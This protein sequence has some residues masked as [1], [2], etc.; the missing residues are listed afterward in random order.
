MRLLTRLALAGRRW[1]QWVPLV[2]S[3]KGY[4]RADFSSDL[5]AGVVVGMVTVPQAVAYAY[6]AG[7]PPQAG[8][9]ACLLPMVIYAC[10]GSSRHLVVGPVAVAALLVAAAIAQHA[11]DYGDAHLMISSVLCLQVGLILLA[12]NLFKMG[13]LVNLLSHPVITGWLNRFTKP[14]ILNR[15]RASKI[16]P[17]CRHSTLEI[18]RCASP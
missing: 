9:Y 17:T 1:Q 6:L 11:P 8:L 10:L 3:L 16:S 14:P 7:L 2:Q 5:S 15:L 13:G 12:L 4:S 18:I